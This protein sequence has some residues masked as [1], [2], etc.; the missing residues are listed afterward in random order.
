MSI[1]VSIRHISERD[2]EKVIIE[3]V[4]VTKDVEDIQS[5]ALTRGT[6][7]TGLNDDRIYWFNLE[8]VFYFEAVDER[9]FAYTEEKVFEMKIRLYE[10]E[11]AYS[12]RFFVRCSKSFVFNLSCRF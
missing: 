9:I 10:L 11:N 4:E 12:E 2:D 5:F 3:C 8:S 1:R 6:T 7:L